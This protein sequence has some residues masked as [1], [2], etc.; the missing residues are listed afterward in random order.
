MACQSSR[1]T[2]LG[3]ADEPGPGSSFPRRSAANDAAD[4]IKALITEG[5][6]VAGSR[7]P[8]E[9]ELCQRLAVSR[10]TLREAIRSLG[11]MGVLQ[12]R[13]GA[14]TYVTDLAAITLAEPLR[15]MIGL[16]SRSLVELADVRRLL[17][18]GAAEFAAATIRPEEL[19]E[20][21]AVID[22]LS[23]GTV[24]PARFIELDTHFH[25]VIHVAARN[26]LLLAL[27]DG[28]GGLAERSREI[29][30]RQPGLLAATIRSHAAIFDALE[31]HDSAAARAAMLDHLDE[32]RDVL[33][34]LL[35]G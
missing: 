5:S 20:L 1:C 11:A 16:N 13:Q 34:E 23:R 27:L 14:G 22:E 15:F 24:H 21:R 32:I 10:P 25:R 19:A 9:R 18:S 26:G 31:A 7:L 30:G 35:D 12:S 6:L 28:V 2:L 8:P 17:E 4:K 33:T 3:V 29:T